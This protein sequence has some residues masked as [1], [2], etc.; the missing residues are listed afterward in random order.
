MTENRTAPVIG[1]FPKVTNT[2]RSLY[3]SFTR[4]NQIHP[5]DPV[6]SKDCKF[7]FINSK[8]TIRVVHFIPE[9]I[10]HAAVVTDDILSK[11]SSLSE[12]YWFK[13]SRPSKS[14][15]CNCSF[16]RSRISIGSNC[17]TS[18]KDSKLDM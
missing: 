16:R 2:W 4:I 13:K 7:I 14:T 10:R 9:K 3:G 6:S 18:Q 1:C 17:V 15:N 5:T 11:R 8:V 12:E